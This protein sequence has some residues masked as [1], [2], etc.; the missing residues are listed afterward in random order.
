MKTRKVL[1]WLIV[2]VLLIALAGCGKTPAET[3]GTLLS[4]EEQQLQSEAETWAQAVTSCG[5]ETDAAHVAAMF[6]TPV[7]ECYRVL[8]D[9]TTLDNAQTVRLLKILI[10][11]RRL[12][13]ER[14]SNPARTANVRDTDGTLLID[15]SEDPFYSE[16]FTDR[17]FVHYAAQRT[18]L[19]V[20]K[21]EVG[22]QK[23]TITVKTG[24]ARIYALTDHPDE[25]NFAC[26]SVSDVLTVTEQDGAWVLTGIFHQPEALVP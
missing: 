1:S 15:A 19:T 26:S 2:G 22:E 23:I 11:Y 20:Q 13:T 9:D 16:E 25:Y 6:E 3:V 5:M 21:V 12:I 17:I 18:T 4:Q 8:T 10:A 24:I 14:V 7:T